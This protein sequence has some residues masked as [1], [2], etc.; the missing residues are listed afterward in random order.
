LRPLGFDRAYRLISRCSP[1]LSNPQ[2]RDALD[3][4]VDIIPE[5]FT[6]EELKTSPPEVSVDILYRKPRGDPNAA[7]LPQE[8]AAWLIK[9]LGFCGIPMK[10]TS[11][12]VDLDGFRTM[13]D[14]LRITSDLGELR[15]R[16]TW[17]I[18]HLREWGARSIR[19]KEAARLVSAPSPRVKEELR[20]L[21][22]RISGEVAHLTARS[23]EIAKVIILWESTPKVLKSGR[24]PGS[25]LRVPPVPFFPD[26][27]L[28]FFSELYDRRPMN[29]DELERLKEEVFG[30]LRALLPNGVS[31]ELYHWFDFRVGRRGEK[32]IVRVY[33]DP[34]RYL[35]FLDAL[36]R[37]PSTLDDKY[38]FLYQSYWGWFP[39]LPN[40]EDLK[41]IGQYVSEYLRASSIWVRIKRELDEL[42]DHLFEPSGNFEKL[43]L[44]E[45]NGA[46]MPRFSLRTHE[47]LLELLSTVSA[48]RYLIEGGYFTAA[49]KELRRML[50]ET[51][52]SLVNDELVFR[53]SPR[54]YEVSV[55]RLPF[56]APS[57]EW[58]R[59]SGAHKAQ[60]LPKE[61]AD[62]FAQLD[63]PEVIAALLG[64]REER[65]DEEVDCD[66][67]EGHIGDAPDL[68]CV[69]VSA[70]R[71]ALAERMNESGCAR[72]L[73]RRLEGYG[74]VDR[75]LPRYPA[76]SIVLQ[77]AEGLGIMGQ[78]YRAMYDEYSRF[79]H[80]YDAT[81]APP[82]LTSVAEAALLA[83][84]L[85]KFNGLLDEALDGYSRHL[86]QFMGAI[87]P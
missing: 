54:L 66:E 22:V 12:L 69:S 59:L 53:S 37:S 86:R 31:E 33:K 9:E 64:S 50:E 27:P 5:V 58:F 28:A 43:M 47:T 17:L 26:M 73:L 45:P 63:Y 24:W 57:G 70:L 13:L 23:H 51:L 77:L 74:E 11:L 8:D 83:I 3:I 79:V 78:S 10:G 15:G 1:R 49:Y 55:G 72:E 4:L 39:M 20:D 56:A 35:D 68:P 82:P 36:A 21:S 16:L 38:R 87:H 67:L 25:S 60:K 81:R 30:S 85:R 52:W 18:V 76:E 40:S 44:K 29:V 62:E 48:I 46:Q 2:I 7:I 32:Y 34:R 42:E 19:L 65:K 61:C 80:A 6:E 41:E 71:S 75:A 14:V 84:E